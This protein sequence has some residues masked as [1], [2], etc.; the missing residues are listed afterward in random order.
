MFMGLM[1]GKSPPLG[2]VASKEM[3][4][5]H[6][7]GCGGAEGHRRLTK[8]Q[9]LI[10]DIKA[11]S[12]PLG[13]GHSERL[14]TLLYVRALSSI[15]ALAP[16][17]VWF[18]TMWFWTDHV[19][20]SPSPSFSDYTVSRNTW[21]VPVFLPPPPILDFSLFEIWENNQNG[22]LKLKYNL[23]T[24]KSFSLYCWRFWQIHTL[25]NL[26]AP[27][28]DIECFHPHKKFPRAIFQSILYP[29]DNRGSDFYHCRLVLHILGFPVNG[30]VHYV[31]LCPASFTLHI[32]FEIH[33]HCVCS[34]SSFSAFL[35]E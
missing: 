2:E 34:L 1:L 6:G 18:W 12:V 3:A 14:L 27:N 26:T 10:D 15:P 29:R 21:F 28:Q 22:F 23:H 5:R 32:T 8:V 33:P 20:F 19:S 30:M 35:A 9:W 24:V 31:F 25:G 16:K 4:E 17:S 13:C 7:A 11:S